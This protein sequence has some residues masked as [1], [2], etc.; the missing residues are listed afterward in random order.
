MVNC[1]WHTHLLCKNRPLW[2]AHSSTKDHFE[3]K[4]S[5]PIDVLYVKFHCECNF[6]EKYWGAVK[7]VATERCDYS[8]AGLKESLPSFLDSVT[9]AAISKYNRKLGDTLTHITRDWSAWKLKKLSRNIDR[10]ESEIPPSRSLYH[11][12][13]RKY[14]R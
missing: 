1:G 6:I 2:G 11:N 4:M 3:F 7:Q 13:P 12:L 5:G 9:L 10:I 8:F 14:T